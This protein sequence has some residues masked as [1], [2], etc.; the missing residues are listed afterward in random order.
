MGWSRL[1]LPLGKC[2]ETSQWKQLQ[3]QR[4]A[5]TV[6][7]CTCLVFNKHLDVQMSQ[8]NSCFRPNFAQKRRNVQ[9]ELGTQK[10]CWLCIGMDSLAA[11]SPP[12]VDQDTCIR[13]G[14]VL[15]SRRYLSAVYLRYYQSTAQDTSVIKH[16]AVCA[17]LMR[18]PP[19]GCHVHYCTA[20]TPSVRY[21]E[22]PKGPAQE[23]CIG[24]TCSA[25]QWAMC[26]HRGTALGRRLR[27]QGG[28]VQKSH[29]FFCWNLLNLLAPGVRPKPCCACFPFNNLTKKVWN[30]IRGWNFRCGRNRSSGLGY[31]TDSLHRPWSVREA[32][33]T[34]RS[35]F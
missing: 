16:L 11:D 2:C 32:A 29:T 13:G 26:R 19:T 1:V 25:V 33:W 9:M 27:P 22:E 3:C 18:A 12:G 15:I 14:R 34:H 23:P 8:A 30:K 7:A 31:V 17:W 6:R 28:L 20:S 4:T 24:R 35:S 5:G 21:R 10:G